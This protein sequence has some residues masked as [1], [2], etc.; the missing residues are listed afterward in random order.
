MGQIAGCFSSANCIVTHVKA[1]RHNTQDVI[2][3]F[4]IMSGGRN[5]EMIMNKAVL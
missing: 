1:S 4:V 2:G 5:N 3:C